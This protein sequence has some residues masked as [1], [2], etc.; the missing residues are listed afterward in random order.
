MQSLTNARPLPLKPI[1]PRHDPIHLLQ[2]SYAFV[3]SVATRYGDLDPQAHI[4]NVSVA[5]IYE[6]GRSQ[7]LHWLVENAEQTLEPPNRMIAQVTINYIS[8]LYYPST[9]TVAT[10]ILQIG[11]SS[12][13]IGQAIFQDGQCCGL[14]ETVVV[15]SDRQRNMEISASWRKTLLKAAMQH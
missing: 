11:R 12:Y 8:Q 10:S 1:M 9:L 4:N 7:F 14:C 5:S 2:S 13:R 15:H 6:E 3:A